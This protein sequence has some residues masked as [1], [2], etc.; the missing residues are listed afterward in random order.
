LLQY[1]PL[2]L[3][4]VI[5]LATLAQHTAHP[6]IRIVDNRAELGSLSLLAVNYLTGLV[7]AFTGSVGM[8][9]WLVLLLTANALFLAFLLVLVAHAHWES[10]LTTLA[11]LC[12][13]CRCCARWRRSPSARFKRGRGQLLYG[14]D[15]ASSS[16][17]ALCCAG[18]AWCWFCCCDPDGAPSYSGSRSRGLGEGFGAGADDEMT[19]SFTLIDH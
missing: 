1:L 18:A 4:L 17:C 6:Y 12:P 16:R 10:A 7:T 14:S 5:Q 2:A 8:S 13:C 9:A 3:L 11:A 15:A 19:G